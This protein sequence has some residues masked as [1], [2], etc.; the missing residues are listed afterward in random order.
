MGI[1]DSTPVG[2][3]LWLHGSLDD[4]EA[5][6]PPPWRLPSITLVHGRETRATDSPRAAEPEH[7]RSG[8]SYPSATT[9]R[10][11]WWRRRDARTCRHPTPAAPDDPAAHTSR[12]HLYR[13]RIVPLTCMGT[14]LAM[15]LT[16]W[17][18]TPTGFILW[19]VLSLGWALSSF[20]AGALHA[21]PD[22]PGRAGT[23][24]HRS[25]APSSSSRTP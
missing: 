1:A 23:G 14:S 5:S 8:M 19:L 4:A 12:P 21:R 16:G 9:D 7:A 17:A 10:I 20:A 6:V 25:G 24:R 22:P 13:T 3:R 18:S 11:T 15:L 2:Y